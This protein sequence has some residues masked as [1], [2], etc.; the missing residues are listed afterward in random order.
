MFLGLGV[1]MGL[2]FL[3][4]ENGI[5]LPLY[6]LVLD[7]TVLRAFVERLPC[8]L[9]WWRRILIWPVVLFVVGYLLWSIP[10]HWGHPGSRDFTVG[11][12]L[13]TEPRILLNYLDKIFL[14]HF[15]IYGLYHDG[16]P[17]SQGLLTPW[18]T[19]PS[20]AIILSLA[21]LALVQADAAGRCSPWPCSGSWAAS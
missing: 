14:P 4:K 12:R 18:T 20:L 8:R 19:L 13:L 21:F 7:A 16:Y 10:A 17:P 9:L 15:G 1:C 11:Q 5:L 2:S 3:S 6:A